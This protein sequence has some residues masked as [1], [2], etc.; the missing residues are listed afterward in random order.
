MGQ[1]WTVMC[2]YNLVN[3]IHSSENKFLLR[4]TLIDEWNFHYTTIS[5]WNATRYAKDALSMINAGLHVEMGDFKD[6]KFK[7]AL[8]QELRDQGKLPDDLFND[9]VRRY[10]RVMFLCGIF[11]DPA[12]LPEGKLNTPEHQE[13]GRKIA[14]EGTVLLKNEGPILPLDISQIHKIAVVGNHAD[15][16]FADGGGSC[17]VGAN[18]EITVR[19]G[20]KLYCKDKVVFVSNPAQADVAIVCV[21]LGHGGP[22]GEGDH[23]GSDRRH[24]DLPAK[25]IALIKN[26]LKRNP[27]T[28][29]ISINGSPYRHGSVY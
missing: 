12:T 28:I 2:S 8:L 4:D 13:I 5:D 19:E 24:F 25:Q 15:K 21:G 16:K 14:E 9:C 20:L 6:Q 11:D 10:L 23:E 29:V 1:A 26:T 18:H 17:A 3:G 22:L 7:P 27:K